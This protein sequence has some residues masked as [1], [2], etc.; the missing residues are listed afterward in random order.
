[1]TDEEWLKAAPPGVQA[2]VRNAMNADK[3]KKDQLVAEITANAANVLD[4]ATLQGM[5]LEALTGIASMARAA[6][7]PVAPVRPNYMGAAAAIVGNSNKGGNKPAVI[8]PL[9]APTMNFASAESDA[10]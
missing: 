8:E 3:M 2:V 1:M 7:A 10:E 9:L 4:S 6:S 5:S